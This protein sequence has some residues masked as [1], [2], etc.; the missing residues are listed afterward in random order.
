MDIDQQIKLLIDNAPQDGSTPA[1]VEAIAP[2]LKQQAA[3]LRHLQ[4]YIVQT[5]DQEWAIT[6]LENR[7]QPD[8]EKN[9]IYAFPT[10]KDTAASPYPVS[11][12]NMVALP[13]P[14]T[15]IL[16]QMLAMD[17]VYSTIFFETP[18]N[19]ATGTE[20]QREMLTRLVEFS[21]GTNLVNP[22][23]TIPPDIA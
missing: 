15:H 17:M 4:Y 1:L 16:F 3:Q 13:V 12:P 9:I 19:T 7:N 11:D 2:I 6:T 21:F 10:L 18:G 23:P 5:L 14:V 8:I 22:Q 20:I